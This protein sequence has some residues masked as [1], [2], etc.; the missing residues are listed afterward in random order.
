MIMT[1][2][3]DGFHNRKDY[4]I[5]ANHYE[6]KGQYKRAFRLYKRGVEKG[7]KSCELNLGYCYDNGIG[8]HKDKKKAMQHYINCMNRGDS[9]GANNV[10]ILFLENG[11]M[12]KAEKY[13]RFAVALG[14]MD[15]ALKLGE[16]FE[17]NGDLRAAKEFY[18]IAANAD[19]TEN[20]TPYGKEAAI[21]KLENLGRHWGE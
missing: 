5:K 21:K 11:D 4:F 8:T 13:L 19:D 17:K 14:D 10:A 12:E 6:E 15:A 20:V 3:K 2:A 16:I 9:A 18:A 1:P 7:D